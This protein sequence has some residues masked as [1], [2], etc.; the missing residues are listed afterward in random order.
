M[1]IRRPALRGARGA[2]R[3]QGPGEEPDSDR[4]VH[5]PA[6][7]PLP[8]QPGPGSPRPDR[9]GGAGAIPGEGNPHPRSY[10]SYPR[11]LGRYVREQGTLTLPEAIHKMTALPAQRMDL[12][13]RGTLAEQY[14]ADIVIFDPQ[15]VIDN[16]T[17]TS[18]HQY[19]TG[20]EY[21]LVNGVIVKTP[22]GMTGRHAGEI[23]THRAGKV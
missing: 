13:D 9:V 8:D 22:Q 23:L 10:G 3:Q 11:V 14:R 12:T 21:I 1:S 17:F 20:I 4:R 5:E 15:T 18:P 6:P 19:P 2:P 7:A 16:A